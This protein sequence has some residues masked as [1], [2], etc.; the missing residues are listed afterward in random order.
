LNVPGENFGLSQFNGGADHS[1]CIIYISVGVISWNPESTKS[2]WE[3][4]WKLTL[5]T[6]NSIEDLGKQNIHFLG[7][8]NFILIKPLKL[9]KW[10]LYETKSSHL[11]ILQKKL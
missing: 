8:T 2:F 4:I 10:K 9:L 5:A 1:P 3:S 7:F 6:E 11:W